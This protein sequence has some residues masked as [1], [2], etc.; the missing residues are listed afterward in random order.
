[1]PNN[2]AYAAIMQ[3]MPEVCWLNTI[4]IITIMSTYHAIR[5]EYTTHELFFYTDVT[6]FDTFFL[7][8]LCGPEKGRWLSK[9]TRV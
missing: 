8:Y 3:L 7:G 4:L 6:I 2:R 9:R 5:I 1:M